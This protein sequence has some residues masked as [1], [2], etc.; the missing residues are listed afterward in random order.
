MS[1]K[2]NGAVHGSLRHDS[3]HKHVAGEALY[4]DDLPEPAGLLHVCF[5]LSQRAHARVLAMDLDAV[6]NAPGVVLVLTAADLP[7]EIGRASC[8][9][10]V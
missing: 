6:R 7:A 8:R 10:R 4:I 9:E 5:G 3:G 1:E 2:I